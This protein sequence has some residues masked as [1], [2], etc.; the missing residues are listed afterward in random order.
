MASS[1]TTTIILTV[2]VAVV[3]G[4]SIQRTISSG[5]AYLGLASSKP[6]RARI[7]G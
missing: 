7:R 2:V 1:I 5:L 4:F 6:L 3:L